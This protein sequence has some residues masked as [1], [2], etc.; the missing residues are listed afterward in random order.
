LRLRG[1]LLPPPHGGRE[2]RDPDATGTYR[3]FNGIASKPAVDGLTSSQVQRRVFKSHW[4]AARIKPLLASLV[5][6][7]L[8]RVETSLPD[9]GGKPV[10][11]WKAALD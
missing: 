7:G 6:S 9:G 3:S 1:F 10:T 11:T 5:R 2:I 8:V 4:K